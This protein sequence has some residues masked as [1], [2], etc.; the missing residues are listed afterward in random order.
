LIDI[1][2]RRPRNR[3]RRRPADHGTLVS[4]RQLG[5]KDKLRNFTQR[6]DVLKFRRLIEIRVYAHVLDF[7]DA[8][9]VDTTEYRARSASVLNVGVINNGEATIN[10][11]VAGTSNTT[12][13]SGE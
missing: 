12:D 10:G 13:E 4:V 7:L 2:G 8:N 11:D 1:G 6:K 5:T 9:D 3:R